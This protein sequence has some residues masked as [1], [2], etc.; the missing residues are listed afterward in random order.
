MIMRSRFLT[1][2]VATLLLVG[3]AAAA[4]PTGPA[5]TPTQEVITIQRTATSGL[6]ALAL[7]GKITADRSAGFFA[8]VDRTAAGAALGSSVDFNATTGITRYGHGSA[9]PLCD[10]PLVCSLDLEHNTLTFTLTETSD[11]DA[12]YDAWK[13]LTRYLTIRGTHL[14]LKVAAI[15]FTVRR[16]AS[17]TFSRVV[18]SD[19]D[20]DGVAVDGIGVEAFRAAQLPGG[21]RGSFAFLQLPCEGE[22]AGAVTFAAT[23]DTLPLVVECKPHVDQVGAGTVYVGTYATNYGEGRYSRDSGKSTLW[24]VNGLATG[25]SATA[26]RL[27]VLSY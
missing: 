11:A 2:L 13:G 21:P 17:A 12:P 6:A 4:A 5:P 26:T 24:Q 27:F 23:G 10:A 16:H 25:V 15:G 14:N 1:A 18:R 8:T 9:S 7:I 20:A 19:A 22:G 3:G